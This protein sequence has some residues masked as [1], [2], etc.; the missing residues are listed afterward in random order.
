MNNLKTVELAREVSTYGKI[1]NTYFHDL[2]HKILADMVAFHDIHE[3]SMAQG[4]MIWAVQGQG[5]M[6]IK[7]LAENLNVSPPSASVMVDRLVEK[8][9]LTRRQSQRDRRKV[10]VELSDY[11][12]DFMEKADHVVLEVFTDLVQKLGEDH[13][14]NWVEVLKRLSVIIEEIKVSANSQK[15]PP[16][17]LENLN[18]TQRLTSKTKTVR[19][20]LPHDRK[21]P[22]QRF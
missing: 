2:L 8:G 16:V 10:V 22:Y 15:Q 6:T 19:K 14:R 21:Y 5:A 9:M 17:A 18:A 11:S 1:L 12:R 13:A 4:H 3:M 20:E 7:E